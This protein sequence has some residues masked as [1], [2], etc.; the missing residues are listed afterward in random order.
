MTTWLQFLLTGTWILTFAL[1]L[2]FFIRSLIRGV[3]GSVAVYSLWIIPVIVCCVTFFAPR[4]AGPRILTHGPIEVEEPKLSTAEPEMLALV[5]VCWT[6]GFLVS[7][8][9]LSLRQRNFKLEIG[10][11]IQIGSIGNVP[12]FISAS[13]TTPMACGIIK[14][15][16]ILPESFEELFTTEIRQLV[17]EHELVHLQRNDPLANLVASIVSSL[18]WFHPLVYWAKSRFRA[19]QEI[20]CDEIVLRSAPHQRRIYGEAL[21]SVCHLENSF[22]MGWLGPKTQVKQRIKALT[23]RPKSKVVRMLGIGVATV[24]AT[25]AGVTAY[26]SLPSDPPKQLNAAANA[27][28]LGSMSIDELGQNLL[29]AI[30]NN[31]YALTRTLLSLGAPIEVAQTGIGTPLILAAKQGNK[32][33]VELLI[34]RDANVNAGVLTAGSPLIMAAKYD[35]PE[36]AQILIEHGSDVNAHVFFDET[37]LINAARFGHMDMVERLVESGAEVNKSVTTFS[38]THLPLGTKSPLSEAARVGHQE[39]VSLLES[40]EN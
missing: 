32:E 6:V 27:S 38:V 40:L 12:M 8:I 7:A 15:R 33:L 25:L 3:F 24:I 9:F 28:L 1:I 26:Q 2:I 13:V 5:L 11:T 16:I 10:E 29:Y 39:I 14:K 20:S 34:E 17:M 19:D 23:S 18:F 4:V 21:L 22:A 35:H 31:D 37:P 30:Q 36:I